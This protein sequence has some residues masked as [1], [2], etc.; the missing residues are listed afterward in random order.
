[1]GGDDRQYTAADLYL[2]GRPH[3]SGVDQDRIF[4]CYFLASTDALGE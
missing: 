4:N 2:D 1:M 3:A